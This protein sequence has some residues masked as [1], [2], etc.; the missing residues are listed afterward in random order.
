MCLFSNCKKSELMK[1]PDVI[2][3]YAYEQRNRI[4]IYNV[5]GDCIPVGIGLA[6]IAYLT[7]KKWMK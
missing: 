2:Y 3:K 4:S 1:H 7:V 6:K 5:V